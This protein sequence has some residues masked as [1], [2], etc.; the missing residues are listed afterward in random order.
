MKVMVIILNLFFLFNLGCGKKSKITPIS[1]PV[2]LAQ[3]IGDG[4]H[5][6]LNVKLPLSDLTLDAIESPLDT[7]GVKVPLFGDFAHLLTKSIYNM[8]ARMGMGRILLKIEQPIPD[9]NSEIIHSIKVKRIF[10]NVEKK[11]ALVESENKTFKKKV[12]EGWKKFR[13]WLQGGKEELNL[14]FLRELKL[15]VSTT[16][17]PVD[18]DLDETSVDIIEVDDLKFKQWNALDK[19][20]HQLLNYKR[21]EKTGIKVLGNKVLVHS[22]APVRAKNY[23]LKNKKMKKVVK[24]VTMINKSLLLELKDGELVDEVF[25]Q[26]LEED[27]DQIETLK[28]FVYVFL[29]L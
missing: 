26:T 16:S 21:E 15:R 2:K 3:T 29:N 17:N 4:E 28:I 7:K 11:D 24:D 14:T 6:V 18:I 9:L 20:T 23:F 19:G 13:Q 5:V 12:K 1:E 8:G 27:E 10:F 22:N 25:F